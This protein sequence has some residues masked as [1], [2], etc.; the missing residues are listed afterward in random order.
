MARG[1]LIA[2]GGMDDE[3]VFWS[4]AKAVFEKI[5]LP[6]RLAVLMSTKK[7]NLAM[8]TGQ[9]TPQRRLDWQ[10]LGVEEIEFYIADESDTIDE[11]MILGL[12]DW[13][14]MIA[15]MGGDTRDYYKH[16]C[17]NQAIAKA[18]RTANQKFQKGIIG[19][20]AGALLFSLDC[21]IWGSELCVGESKLLL[22]SEFAKDQWQDGDLAFRTGKG[23]GLF[24]DVVIDV[25]CTQYGRIPRL[26]KAV[27][28]S[29]WGIGIG[30]D[31]DV[32][33]LFM[34]NEEIFCY[35]NGF[36]TVYEKADSQQSSGVMEGAIRL[37]CVRD[38]EKRLVLKH[39]SIGAG[40]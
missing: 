36:V 19:V 16:Y 21:I 6:K 39:D 18:I 34:P 38:G 9:L 23:L 25:H 30:I 3:T 35:G 31:A 32:G 15:I 11:K 29:K 14:D 5:G 27:S 28:E 10:R 20:S 1:P 2:F 33:V 17:G 13:S 40:P 12:V 26:I 7:E 37:Y 24:E 8:F 22:Q 4:S